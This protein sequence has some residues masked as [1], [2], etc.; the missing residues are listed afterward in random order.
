MALP[1]WLNINPSDYLRAVEAGTRAGLSIRQANQQAFENAQRMQ[2]ESEAHRERAKQL[3]V[4]N[5]ANRLAQERLEQY[6][7]GELKNAQERFGI[8]RQGLGLRQEGMTQADQ[9]RALGLDLRERSLKDTE[10][11]TE[12]SQKM[13]GEKFDLQKQLADLRDKSA[14]KPMIKTLRDGRVVSIATDNKVTPLTVP[15]RPDPIPDPPK[16]GMLE[17]LLSRLRHPFTDPGQSATGASLD[18]PADPKARKPNIKYRTPKGEFI[19]TGQGWKKPDA[20]NIPL[21]VQP[22]QPD[23]SDAQ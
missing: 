2:M 7:Q 22:D 14:N 21:T 5:A 23:Q 16:P 13:A 6:R 8:E 12:A 15:P 1:P 20:G 19:W 17:G 18:A 3:E 11:R 4:E 9:A 10:A